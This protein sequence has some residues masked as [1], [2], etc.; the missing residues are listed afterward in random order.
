MQTISPTS[1]TGM[2]GTLGTLPFICPKHLMVTAVALSALMSLP[3]VEAGKTAYK[4]CF[5]ACMNGCQNAAIITL[6]ICA[7]VCA[8]TLP[9]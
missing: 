6:P 9:F 5:T 1:S 4:A 3:V 7:T 2:R 8:V